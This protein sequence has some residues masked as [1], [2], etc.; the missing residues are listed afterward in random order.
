MNVKILPSVAYG[1]INA[2]PSK[3]CAHRL[4]ICAALAKG[5]SVIN[6]IGTN[7]DIVAT[8]SCLKELGAKI[9]IIGN[10]AVVRG[11]ENSEK[12]EEL[13][14]FCNESG[15]TLRFLIPLSL[16]FSDLVYFGGSQRLLERPQSVYEELFSEKGCYLKK[17]DNA[18]VAGGELKSGTYSLL[19]DVSSQ[20]LTGLLFTLPLLDGDSEIVL[21]T[22]LQ[23]APYVDITIDV[24]SEFGV[25]IEKGNNK[26]YIK[27]NQKYLPLNLEVEGDWSNSA[28]LEAFNLIGGN[29][30][31]LG[32][33]EES[34]QGD[35]RYKEFYEQIQNGTPTLDISDCP[36]LG[37]VLIACSA[38]C[39]GAKLVGTKR[40]KIKESDR[41]EAMKTELS[42]FG[43]DIVVQEDEIVVPKTEMKIPEENLN[44]HNDHRIAMSLAILC[45]KVGGTLENA[46]CVNKSYPEFFD[47]IKTLGIQIDIKGDN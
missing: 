36:D 46:Q 4:L 44:C 10:K 15:S 40:L 32:M 39:N 45:S 28:F 19:G 47:D 22:P 7:D 6:N 27:G 25:R 16:V 11:I 42:K 2:P 9:N 14:L 12:K 17:E 5:E 29:V 31:V 21:T 18:L 1:K 20:F 37:P 26:F 24:L 43:V 34:Y 13:K 8:I 35:K 30:E 38:L 3:S 33:N 41:G 23:S